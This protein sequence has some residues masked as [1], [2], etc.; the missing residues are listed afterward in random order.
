MAGGRGGPG[1]AP[2]GLSRT[3]LVALVAK[4]DVLTSKPLAV[5]LTEEQKTKIQATLKGLGEKKELREDDAKRILDAILQIVENDKETLA[6]AGFPPGSPNA[7]DPNPFQQ[8]ANA[9]H[10]KALQ[11]RLSSKKAP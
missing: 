10:L 9:E 6:A 7:S 8:E 3:Q 2:A 1:G 4:L 11:A 5:N